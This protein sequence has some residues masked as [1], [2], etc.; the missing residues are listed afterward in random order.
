MTLHALLCGS[1]RSK[2]VGMQRNR[3]PKFRSQAFLSG[4]LVCAAAHAAEPSPSAVATFNAYAEAVE[5]RLARQHRSASG[6]LAS[7]AYDPA[8]EA[9]LRRGD[10]IVEQL[11]PPSG[12]ALPGALLHDWRGRAF[13]PGATPSDFVRLMRGIDAWPQ[14]YAP[15]VL[16]AAVLAQ[17]GDHLQAAMRVRQ[18]HVITVT[19]DSTY[20]ITFGRLDAQR[21]FSLS[22]S[23]RIVE[24]DASGH[25]LPAS[26]EHG[27]LWR[28]NTY[29]SYEERDGG[30]YLQVESISLSRSIP[31][32]LAWAV[33]PFIESV[34][35]DS[36]E[37][38]L[39]AT[40][41]ALR[42]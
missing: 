15:Q 23:T 33:A 27:F 5:V 4:L 30:L 29:W 28:L 40:C 19:M 41:N 25:A 6:F 2:V 7:A 11:T 26:Q 36:L 1:R 37:F 3:I 22:R 14:V 21:G 39:R 34:P 31:T 9:R 20:D 13:A 17:D 18:R 16:R 42:K 35:R 12:A 24:V 32:G 10:L 38:T 8:N